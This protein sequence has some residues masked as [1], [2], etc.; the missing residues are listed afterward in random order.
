LKFSTDLQKTGQG[1]GA[2]EVKADGLKPAVETADDVEDEG[3]VGDRFAEVAEI[4]RLALVLPAVVS[5]RE[6]ALTEGPEVSIGVQGTRGLIPKKLRLNGEP[7]VAGGGAVLG[8]GV[9]KV[10][11]DGAKEPSPHDTVHADP[12]GGGRDGDVR[13]DMALQGVPPKGEEEGFMPPGVGGCPVEAERDEQGDVL[14]RGHLGV[15]V[16]E[17]G[18]LV[19]GNNIV[20]GLV[21]DG[22]EGGVVIIIIVDRRRREIGRSAFRRGTVKG[23]A[24][25]SVGCI[26]LGLRRGGLALCISHAGECS[27]T[28]GLARVDVGGRHRPAIRMAIA[29]SSR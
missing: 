28:G 12:V 2:A 5:D 29:G 7:D 19:L 6:V 26:V 14:Y 21:A 20:D 3:A 17:R 4:L 8:D 13:E 25:T 9:G 15:E 18:G 24:K 11:G 23:S 27:V 1:V 16:E 10:V 22:G